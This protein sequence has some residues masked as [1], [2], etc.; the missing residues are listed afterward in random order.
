MIENEVNKIN[1]AT[2]RSCGQRTHS[3]KTLGRIAR[4]APTQSKES[5]NGLGGPS[6]NWP[7][8]RARTFPRILINTLEKQ[9][10]RQAAEVSLA[11]ALA[12]YSS[13]RRRTKRSSYSVCALVFDNGGASVFPRVGQLNL[14]GA[15]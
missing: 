3:P 12:Q 8:R 1:S 2:R 5:V 14:G 9:T 10:A 15:P 7:L 6:V 4:K 11:A 13:A